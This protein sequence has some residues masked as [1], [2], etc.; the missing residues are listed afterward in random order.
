MSKSKHET[1][2]QVRKEGA[3]PEQAFELVR[4]TTAQIARVYHRCT[5]SDIQRWIADQ[6]AYGDEILLRALKGQ[7]TPQSPE[8]VIREWLD[9]YH[10]GMNL[11]ANLQGI[12]LPRSHFSRFILVPQGLTINKVFEALPF[13]KR[14]VWDDLDRAINPEEEQRSPAK[15]AYAIAVRDSIEADILLNRT[16]NEHRAL[17]IMTETI[18]E[19]LI[20]V[21]KVHRE[22]K[23][24]LDV[25]GWTRC[26]GSR[27]VDGD[28]PSCSAR[29]GA[30]YV[31]YDS[32]DSAYPGLRAREVVF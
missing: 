11:D 18:L 1:V 13:P 7:L 26:D 17:G 20:H 27:L 22:T 8:E 9:F 4:A 6:E 2:H 25:Q 3:T 30:F 28:V 15:Q 12:I 5:T 21:L 16:A 24:H 23:Q 10:D 31:H 29:G 32:P 19:H 14:S